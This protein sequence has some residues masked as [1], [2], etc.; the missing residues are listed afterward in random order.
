MAQTFARRRS[1]IVYSPRYEIDLGGHIWPTAKYRLIAERLAAERV[2]DPASFV[3]PAMCS[4]EDL[5]LVHTG[6]Y[7]GKVRTSTLT[8]DEIATLELPWSPGLPTVS[9]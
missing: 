6:E 9:E 3:T 2:V 7:L 8:P 4:W 5:A 1:A